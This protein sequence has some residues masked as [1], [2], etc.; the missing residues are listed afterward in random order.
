MPHYD[1]IHSRP[2]ATRGRLWIASL[3]GLGCALAGFAGWMTAAPLES[4]SVSEFASVPALM[5]QVEYYMTKRLEQSLA[6]GS[7]YSDSA[8][9]R[10]A[11]DGATLVVL[12]MTLGLH[13]Q[14]SALKPSAPRLVELAEDLVASSDGYAKAKTAFE[15]LQQG[16]ANGANGGKPLSWQK[17]CELVLLMKQVTTVHNNL[18]Q[19][20]KSKSTLTKRKENA[21]GKAALLAV[22]GQATLVD[23]D[24]AK[25]AIKNVLDDESQIE[26]KLADW[27]RYSILMRDSAGGVAQAAMAG[28]Y[29][30]VAKQKDILQKSCDDCHEAFDIDATEEVEE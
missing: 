23:T 5:S 13:D 1:Q 28:D 27:N 22:I 6:D 24:A 3:L 14:D 26:Q 29:D 16:I 21:A 15:A 11:K 4:P 2:L 9:T 17:R 20:S 7:R 18:K 30:A 12:F 8:K 19:Y 10:V 25:E